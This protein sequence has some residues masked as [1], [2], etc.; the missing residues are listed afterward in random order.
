MTRRI[1]L[2][3]KLECPDRLVTGGTASLGLVDGMP[4]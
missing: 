4:L 2:L 1:P 3:K